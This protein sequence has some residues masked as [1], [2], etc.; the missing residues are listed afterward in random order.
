MTGQR[1][2]K[3]K[4]EVK[5]VWRKVRQRGRWREGWWNAHLIDLSL[6]DD[7]GS[8]DKHE[9]AKQS[10]KS[11]N[12]LISVP[13]VLSISVIQ[14]VLLQSDKKSETSHFKSQ[15]K[16]FCTQNFSV[17]FVFTLHLTLT[18]RRWITKKNINKK[19]ETLDTKNKYQILKLN[20]NHCS[21]DCFKWA[22]LKDSCCTS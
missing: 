18:A 13:S 15:R 16:W 7:V 8:K 3:Q 22:W 20:F 17:A 21:Y 6:C 12:K 11:L 9:W 5:E 19:K 14:S 1:K 4:R 10:N 2:N